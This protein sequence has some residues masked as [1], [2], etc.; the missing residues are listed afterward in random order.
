[1]F[2]KSCGLP[3]SDGGPCGK[4]YEEGPC[5]EKQCVW[6]KSDF[7]GGGGGSPG[8]YIP[9]GNTGGGDDSGLY[10]NGGQ[11][12]GDGGSPCSELKTET[13]C[14]EKQS[15]QGSGVCEW[16]ASGAGGEGFAEGTEG[17]EG[18]EGSDG[19]NGDAGAEDGGAG[20]DGGEDQSGELG[21]STEGGPDMS[22]G[23]ATGMCKPIDVCKGGNDSA[24]LCNDYADFGCKWADNRCTNTNSG[25]MGGGAST[26]P[27]CEAIGG[28]EKFATPGPYESTAAPKSTDAPTGQEEAGDDATDSGVDD[29]TAD[30]GAADEAAKQAEADKAAA[31]D[32]AVAAAEAILEA[33]DDALKLAQ[34]AAEE[35]D[36]AVKADEAEL[37]KLV[38]ATKDEDCGEDP[39]ADGISTECQEKLTLEM[40]IQL[41][42][43]QLL[44]AQ[45][46]LASATAAQTS[47][48]SALI[49]AKAAAS[50]AETVPDKGSGALIGGIVGAVV[51][52][53]IIGIAVV[54]MKGGDSAGG[55]GDGVPNQAYQSPGIQ[56]VDAES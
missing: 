18:T 7:G 1:V 19:G 16:E 15:A 41:L 21:Q 46:D 32:A 20:A 54:V 52:L 5:K 6:T 13:N 47:A 53:V 42:Q 14:K 49:A 3:K 28:K 30:D 34:A 22:G 37:V 51:V 33:A 17:T 23:D 12:G 36:A 24:E 2:K 44:T 45:A 31:L 48:S 29:S 8:D 39:L 4:V 25:S 56:F 11:N 43:T 38:T 55:H 27:R 50:G 26:G 40:Q 35:A 10:E 9:G